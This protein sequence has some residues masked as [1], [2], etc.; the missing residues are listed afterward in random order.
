MEL[1]NSTTIILFVV[2]L[3][4]LFVIGK[5]FEEQN[6]RYVDYKTSEATTTVQKMRAGAFVLL[7][8]LSDAAFPGSRDYAISYKRLKRTKTEL[9][10]SSASGIN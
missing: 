10:N 4:A 3:G 5:E 1:L 6:P 9:A 7:D 2:L 8:F